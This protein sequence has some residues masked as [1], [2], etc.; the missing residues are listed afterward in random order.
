MWPGPVVTNF[1]NRAGVSFG[2]KSLSSSYVAK[3][4][5]T[6]LF[7]GKTVIIPGFKMKVVKFGVRFLPDKFVARLTYNIQ[8]KKVK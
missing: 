4:G 5:L 3:Y 1:N 2:V 7:S 8:K 6:K